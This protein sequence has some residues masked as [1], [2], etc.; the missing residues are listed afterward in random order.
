[1]AYLNHYI[2]DNGLAKFQAEANRLDITSQE[3]ATYAEATSTYSLGNKTSLIIGA[4]EDRGPNGRKVVV[5]AIANGSVT[6]SG[7]VTHW[8]VSDTASSRLLAAGP[9]SSSQGVT[10]GNVFTLGTIDIGIPDAV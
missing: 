7:T 3:A 4:P 1:M 2:H 6:A 8:A 10:A 9:L 5:A